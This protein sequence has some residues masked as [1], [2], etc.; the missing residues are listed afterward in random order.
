[1]YSFT[2]WVSNCDKSLYSTTLFKA[3]ENKI[4]EEKKDTAVSELYERICTIIIII[5]FLV[6]NSS[7]SYNLRECFYYRN[8]MGSAYIILFS[9]LYQQLGSLSLS[10]VTNLS[11][12]VLSCSWLFSTLV[13]LQ[14]RGSRSTFPACDSYMLRHAAGEHDFF[15]D[16]YFSSQQ[17][18]STRFCVF[19]QQKFLITEQMHE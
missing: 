15:L 4:Q 16:I 7:H 12:H 2:L 6:S 1:M 11:C 18:S 14:N 17:V 13:T 10:L 9:L 5:I 8:W 19:G 3:C